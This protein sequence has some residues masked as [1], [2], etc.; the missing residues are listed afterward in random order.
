MLRKIFLAALGA[1]GFGA[2][3][4]L[5]R[6][7]LWI[8][9][10]LSGLSW[11]SYML[12]EKALNNQGTAMFFITIAVAIISKLYAMK[13]KCPAFVISTPVLIPFIPGA[14]LYLVM[15]DF[16]GDRVTLMENL[17]MLW[18]QVGA[19]VAGN[20]AVEVVCVKLLYEKG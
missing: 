2:I 14:T 10:L 5:P 17:D 13:M 4:G 8:I 18:K 20:L 9:G 1:A 3:F 15:N 16:V 6:N 7:K 11:G 12:L 19:I